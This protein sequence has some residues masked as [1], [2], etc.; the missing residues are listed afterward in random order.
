MVRCCCF[1]VGDLK[2]KRRILAARETIFDF[3]CCGMSFE[4]AERAKTRTS[5]S[6]EV[7]DSRTSDPVTFLFASLVSSCCLR[8]HAGSASGKA[9]GREARD[10]TSNTRMAVPY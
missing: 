6:V 2:K 1:R 7:S 5:Q 9:A 8:V 4:S 3:I 10:T